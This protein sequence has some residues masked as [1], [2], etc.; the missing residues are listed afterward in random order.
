MTIVSSFDDSSVGNFFQLNDETLTSNNINELF[1]PWES[2]EQVI[3][4]ISGQM[5]DLLEVDW[6]VI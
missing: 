3:V 4:N 1:L 2:M 6:A 5:S